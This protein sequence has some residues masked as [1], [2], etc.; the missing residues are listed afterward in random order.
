[1]LPK[2]LGIIQS[3]RCFIDN[4]LTRCPAFVYENAE[5]VIMQTDAKTFEDI[6][7]YPIC[8]LCAVSFYILLYIKDLKICDINLSLR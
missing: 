3:G 8:N 1:M 2:S 5:V 7:P 6:F 4:L